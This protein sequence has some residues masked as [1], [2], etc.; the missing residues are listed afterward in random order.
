MKQFCNMRWLVLVLGGLGIAAG[1]GAQQS[2]Q[3]P[4]VVKN[5][6]ERTKILVLKPH[7]ES[8]FTDQ[9]KTLQELYDSFLFDLRFADVFMIV[10]GNPATTYLDQQD[11]ERNLIDYAEWRRVE[12]QQ[13]HLDYVV[14]TNLIP[15]GPGFFELDL[16]VYDVVQGQ[17]IIGMAYGGGGSPFTA[18]DLRRAG[19]RATAEIIR[20]ITNNAVI[21]ITESRIAF[22]NNI[23]SKTIKEIYVMDYDGWEKSIV[24]VTFFNS[25]TL[26]PEWSPDGNELAYV[27]YKDNWP[28][29]FIQNLPSGKVSVL[30]KFEGTNTTPRWFPDGQH[31]AISLSAQGN[32]EIYQISKTGKDPKRLTFNR[33]IDEA[34]DVSPRGNQIAFTSDRLE[35]PQIYIMDVDGANTRRISYVERKCDEAQWSPVPIGDDYRI[36]FTGYTSGLQAD[37]YT[38]RPD[39]SDSQMITDGKSH[40]QNPTWSP[41]GKYIAFSSNRLGK[42][43]VFITSNNPNKALPN[44][45]KFYQLTHF[46]G[47]NLSPAWSPK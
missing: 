41:D 20:T 25:I 38:V 21:P 22:V 30:A 33:W 35:S 31:L 44:G 17:R 3:V 32:A 34:P 43:E 14:K 10:E 46:S 7:A 8:A 16:Y 29:A 42:Y 45:Q 40:N 15:R 19:H 2:I 12:I 28:D 6:E 5:P 26:F 11:R 13:I 9:E 37:I 23:P 1:V 36:A 27:S 47:E 24:R 39:G 18:K 4:D